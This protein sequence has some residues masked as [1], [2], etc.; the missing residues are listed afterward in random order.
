MAEVVNGAARD[1]T[2]DVTQSSENRADELAPL[3]VD[4]SDDR[5]GTTFSLALSARRALEGRFHVHPSP[6]VFVGHDTRSEFEKMHGPM[7]RQILLILTGLSEQQLRDLG[8]AEFRE[9][10]SERVLA[11]WKA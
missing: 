7:L 3:V 11:E 5:S 10:V 1:H 6:R 4:V 8:R 9:A 2:V